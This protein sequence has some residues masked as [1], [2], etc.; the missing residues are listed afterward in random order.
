MRRD[1]KKA[2]KQKQNKTG[3]KRKTSG[4]TFVEYNEN[5]LL[6]FNCIGRQ[7]ITVFIP[8]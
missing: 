4:G 2:E 8:V 3:I 7:A 5:K 6:M 1:W